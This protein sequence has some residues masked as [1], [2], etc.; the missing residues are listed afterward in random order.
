MRRAVLFAGLLM[1]AGCAKFPGAGS[2][3]FTKRLVLTMKLSGEVQYGQN[4]GKRYI[5][6]IALR[7][8]KDQNPPDGPI[9]VVAPGSANGL[10]AGACTDYILCDPGSATPY[11][12]WHFQDAALTAATLT[13]TAIDR[14][15]TANTLTCEVDLSQLVPLSDVNL[16]KSVQVN[17]FA[18]D[19][20]AIGSTSHFWDALGNS[21][22]VSEFNR[23]LNLT[24]DSSRRITNQQLQ[25]EPSTLDV[26]GTSDPDLDVS[27][28]SV[29]IL[30]QG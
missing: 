26:N 12:I 5:Y 28:W 13:G 8:S 14:N 29:E 18:M 27:D 2:G 6:L 10:V 1:L 15:T 24:L 9:P 30:L 11:Q 23:Y 19:R 22:S 21:R 25:V 7:M 17:F 4:L 16:I 3:S 20:R